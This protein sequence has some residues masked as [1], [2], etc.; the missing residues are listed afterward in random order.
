MPF[1]NRA[2]KE[3]LEQSLIKLGWEPYDGDLW[4][5]K[6]SGVIARFLDVVAMELQTYVQ[7]KQVFPGHEFKEPY[8]WRH[9]TGWMDVWTRYFIHLLVKIKR[10]PSTLK[11]WLDADD[12]WPSR[13]YAWLE[14]PL[15]VVQRPLKPPASKSSSRKGT[16][17]D[18]PGKS[19]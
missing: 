2:I 12:R 17:S 6:R 10:L 1:M 19:R 8:E 11:D 9:R 4:R 7:V 16:P 3:Q 13:V 15:V 18:V 14:G 5:Y